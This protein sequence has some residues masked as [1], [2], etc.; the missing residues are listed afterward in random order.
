[1]GFLL[2]KLLPL[3]LYPLGLALL[4]QLTGLLARRRR[5]GPW[6]GWLG[7]TLLWLASMPLISRQL[8]WSLEEQAS[9]LTP[10][11]LS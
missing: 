7:L 9:R 1:M 5:W 11:P 3:V 10:S 2:S 4:L 6:L 8:V